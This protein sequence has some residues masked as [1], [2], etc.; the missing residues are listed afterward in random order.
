MVP[1]FSKQ[2]EQREPKKRQVLSLH[3]KLTILDG[4]RK[5]EVG[6]ALAREYGIGKA[7]ITDLKRREQKIRSYCAQSCDAALKQTAHMKGSVGQCCLPVV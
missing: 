7:T 2:K 6:S 5:G 3:T 1:A 4:L